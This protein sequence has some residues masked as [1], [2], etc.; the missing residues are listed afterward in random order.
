MQIGLISRVYVLFIFI[1]WTTQTGCS[2]VSQSQPPRISSQHLLKPDDRSRVRKTS[3]PE[4]CLH[5]QPVEHYSNEE[6]TST[7]THTEP[8]SPGSPRETLCIPATPNC[9]PQ[10]SPIGSPRRLTE[11]SSSSSSQ[12]PDSENCA[13]R[14]GAAGERVRKK[15]TNAGDDSR[16]P[17]ISLQYSASLSICSNSHSNPH[18]QSRDSPELIASGAESADTTESELPAQ[19]R[20]QRRATTQQ[21]PSLTSAAVSPLT[22]ES[23]SQLPP[24]ECS[25]QSLCVGIGAG[26][27]SSCARLGPGHVKVARSNS[28][29]Q[30]VSQTP[31]PFL[32][33][34]S[35]HQ[36]LHLHLSANAS[37]TQS[38][39]LMSQSQSGGSSRMSSRESLSS[40][41]GGENPSQSQSHLSTYAGGGE[42]AG[43]GAGGSVRIKGIGSPGPSPGVVQ[44]QTHRA[45]APLIFCPEPSDETPPI[46]PP[47]DTKSHSHRHNRNHRN[48]P[49]P[50]QHSLERLKGRSSEHRTSDA[51]SVSSV[52]SK[53]HSC[54]KRHSCSSEDSAGA[55]A[56]LKVD[57]N[58]H[59]TGGRH[60]KLNSRSASI[61][62]EHEWRGANCEEGAA[63]R[64]EEARRG[65][66]AQDHKVQ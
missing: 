44:H 36:N 53:D 15:A 49:L 18:F 20:R 41:G 26:A 2:A 39:T 64:R 57:Q 14:G 30:S 42:G 13:E 21:T 65:S 66:L 4:R 52:T 9:T 60:P 51:G 31:S 47:G 40:N 61:R 34:S 24:R 48:A 19:S 45:P 3:V 54:V 56:L 25:S 37:P 8:N 38:V 33:P 22:R 63:R 55:D 1:G 7:P 29:R 16:R 59:L 28:Q 43:A 23:Q 58:G 46:S 35:S 11:A 10:P 62:V 27:S 6:P 32:T 50:Q 17:A 12:R 5:S